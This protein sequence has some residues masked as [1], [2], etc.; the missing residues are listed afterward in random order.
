MFTATCRTWNQPS[1]QGNFGLK[2][3][4]Q[5]IGNQCLQ[6]ARALSWQVLGMA[7]VLNRAIAVS[8]KN[9]RG[10]QWLLEIWSGDAIVMHRIDL[11]I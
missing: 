6:P 2:T 7:Y 4:P 11:I 9:I 10:R 3:F 1:L 5:R 8:S